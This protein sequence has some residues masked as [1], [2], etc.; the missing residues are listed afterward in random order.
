MKA[1]KILFLALVLTLAGCSESDKSADHSASQG[2]ASKMSFKTGQTEMDESSD[3]ETEQVQTENQDHE[4]LTGKSQRKVIYHAD[5]Q[6]EVKD[7]HETQRE[8]E[9]KAKEFGGYIVES[10][11]SEYDSHLSGSMTFRIP[12]GRF[13]QF[14]DAAEN[15]ASKMMDRNVTGRD[16]TE[17]YVDLESRLRSKKAVEVRLLAF[18][19]EAENTG[20]LLK[21]SKELDAVQEEIEQLAGRLQFLQNQTAYATVT[22]Y[23]GEGIKVME[24]GD[25]NTWE[26]VEKQFTRN[27][28]F[29]MS[30]FSGV[31]VVLIGNI[32]ALILTG[33]LAAA[34][35]AVYRKLRLKERRTEREKTK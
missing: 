22:I 33:L 31:A 29:L 8:L 26:R 17:E 12:E 21:I 20:D 35:F 15:S 34:G 4:T 1:I 23:M 16:V 25:L 18:M 5:V 9:T 2:E 11:S 27:I 14:I 28:N 32:P 30:F 7:F 19:E 13:Q 6:L 10:S 24:Q 3:R